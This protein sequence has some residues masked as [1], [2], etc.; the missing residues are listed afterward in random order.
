[1]T[2][3]LKEITKLRL[4]LCRDLGLVIKD[5]HFFYDK[6]TS[7]GYREIIGQYGSHFLQ[8]EP[9]DTKCFKPN[10]TFAALYDFYQL[11]QHLKNEA[12]IDVQ[13]FEQSFKAALVDS[14]EIES[15]TLRIKKAKSG[16]DDHLKLDD[17]LEEKYGL[18]SGR[19]IRRGDLRSRIRRIKQNYLEPF[20][21]YNQLHHEIT[22]WVMIKEMSFG[23]ACNYFFLLHQRV[24]E[25]VLKI[26][27]KDKTPVTNF[28]KVVETI[29]AFRDRA[30][31][32]YRLIGIKHEGV[33][34]YCLMYQQLL[35]M[36]NQEPAERMKANFDRIVEKYLS[37]HPDERQYLK[38]VLLK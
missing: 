1:M 24:Q 11:D 10:T 38:E 12:L 29:R 22:P 32:N 14:V 35:L 36:N 31:H 21:G 28:E 19:V 25:N 13:L 23:V 20:D 17:F 34:Y 9:D 2:I 30:A 6:V 5:D 8:K 4:D 16:K 37:N 18:Q 27:F 7:Y 26:L 15:M 33:F 3:D